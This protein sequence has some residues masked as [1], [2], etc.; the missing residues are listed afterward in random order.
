MAQQVAA[1][2]AAAPLGLGVGHT[3]RLPAITHRRDYIIWHIVGIFPWAV[4]FDDL[5]IKP[6]LMRHLDVRLIFPLASEGIRH[7]NVG[8]LDHS[9]GDALLAPFMGALYLG[10][11]KSVFI[12]DHVEHIGL[13]MPGLVNQA[14][15]QG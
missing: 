13:E 12:A 10:G 5:D 11:I 9:A 1:A 3:V 7:G 15:S 6:A 4:T 14:A 8:L 2:D